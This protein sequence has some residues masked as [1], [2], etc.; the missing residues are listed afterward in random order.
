MRFGSWIFEIGH[1]CHLGGGLAGWLMG[2]WI[3]RPR[4]TL[5]ELQKE[6]ARREARNAREE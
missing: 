6:R 5:E 2:L 1:A 4:I 3:L